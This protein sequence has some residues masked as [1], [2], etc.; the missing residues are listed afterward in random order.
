MNKPAQDSPGDFFRASIE[1]RLSAG[2]DQC[3]AVLEEAGWSPPPAP[4]LAPGRVQPAAERASTRLRQ[5]REREPR[6]PAR[7]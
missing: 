4:V 3:R 5:Q 7:T 6:Q 1:R 2:Y